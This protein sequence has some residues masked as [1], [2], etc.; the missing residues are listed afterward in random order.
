M[1]Q[2]ALTHGLWLALC[3]G[4][5]SLFLRAEG[6]ELMVLTLKERKYASRGALRCLDAALASNGANCER[7][8]DIRGLKTLM[9]LLGSA[10][11]PPPAFVK[12]KVSPNPNPNPHPHPDPN[13]NP[14][15]DPNPNPKAEREAMQLQHDEHL[16]SLLVTLLQQLTVRIRVRIRVRV[17]V[18]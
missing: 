9:P 7:F 2:V 13:P 17:R 11:A 16:A 1:P 3:G 12:G 15:P 4:T 14:N 6:I 5:E 18:S 8:V 10:P